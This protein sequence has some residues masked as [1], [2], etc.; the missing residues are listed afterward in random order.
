MIEPESSTANIF[1]TNLPFLLSPADVSQYVDTLK[2][3]KSLSIYQNERPYDIKPDHIHW[4]FADAYL[5]PS[6][7]EKG[8]CSDFE[9]WMDLNPKEET[10]SFRDEVIN[11]A[12]LLAQQA[13]GRK[14]A[15]CLSGGS[16]S[17]VIARVL[18]S[19][20][21]DFQGYFL[22]FW[23]QNIS[24]Y[25]EFVEPLQKDL[26]IDV[27]VIELEK[28][29]FFEEFAPMQF[30]KFGCE[31]PT[32][33]AM[34]YLFNHIPMDEFIVTGEGDIDKQGDLYVKLAN[35]V[36]SSGGNLLVPYCTSEIIY[37]L[38]AQ[39]NQRH[40][41]FYFFNS[42][43]SLVLATLRNKHLKFEFPHLDAKEIIYSSFPEVQKRRKTNNWEGDL[44][45]L[46]RLLRTRLFELA[47]RN[48]L[49]KD[50]RP[51]IGSFQ[52]LSPAQF[53]HRD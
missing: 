10:K 22:S 20:G 38:W 50:W 4:R 43:P 53:C 17:E 9:Y 35:G 18:C 8:F 46:N 31:Y 26:S 24:N 30:L 14:I 28:K 39:K 13:N 42:T 52:D 16:D 32:Y 36:K 7:N 47:A 1:L 41:Q 19:L 11:A 23:N 12:Q 21:I 6:L 5:G 33:L 29:Y 44:F 37:R 40:G 49:M 2:L 45:K 15:L 3:S 51:A 34:L 48:S 25:L 27:K